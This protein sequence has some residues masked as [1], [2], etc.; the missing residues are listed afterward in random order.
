MGSLR[1][2]LSW[3]QWEEGRRSQNSS[4]FGRTSKLLAQDSVPTLDRVHTRLV[5]EPVGQPLLEFTTYTQLLLAI[6][7]AI[8]GNIFL[9]GIASLLTVVGHKYM[10]TKHSVLHRDV[11]YGNILLLPAPAHGMLIDFDMATFTDRSG[12]S[13]RRRTG[14]FDFMAA[15]IL[16]GDTNH[17]VRHDLESFFYVLLWIAI[18]FSRYDGKMSARRSPYPETIFLLKT[19]DNQ[20]ITMSGFAR[21]G[22]MWNHQR[23]ENGI[24]PTLDPDAKDAL[25]T[26]FLD[27]REALYPEE[28]AS[29]DTADDPE[30]LYM[31]VL[32]ILEKTIRQLQ[33]Q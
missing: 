27:W 7:E 11:S 4:H 29:Q 5:I 16:V 33:G 17:T 25:G 2:G 9:I 13:A 18:C 3:P 30:E 6:R 1:N 20:R 24:L 15:D 31:R 22:M 12:H 32:K 8:K 23:F 21:C 19:T 14:T 26:L 10:Y 28:T